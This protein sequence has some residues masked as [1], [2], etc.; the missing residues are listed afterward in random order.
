MGL[1][2]C[3][4]ALN[5]LGED[6]VRNDILLEEAELHATDKFIWGINCK[7]SG[8]IKVSHPPDN[9]VASRSSLFYSFHNR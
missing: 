8:E 5:V 3:R 6:Q 7:V 2:P 1:H 9:S 4:V